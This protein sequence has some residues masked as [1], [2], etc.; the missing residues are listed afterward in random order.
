MP[1]SNRDD[2]PSHCGSGLAR[3]GITAVGLTDRTDPIASKP[4]PTKTTT[5]RCDLNPPSSSVV[6]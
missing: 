6:D 3:D 5:T 4:A 1:I 2:P